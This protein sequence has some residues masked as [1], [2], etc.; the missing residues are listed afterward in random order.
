V[1]GGPHA[2]SATTTGGG[3]PAGLLPWTG[4]DWVGLERR[5]WWLPC[6]QAES[7]SPLAA[8]TL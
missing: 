3:E 5:G 4:E 1:G 6:G 7:L 2:S 8:P